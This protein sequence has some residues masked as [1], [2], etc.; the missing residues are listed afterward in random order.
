MRKLLIKLFKL[1]KFNIFSIFIAFSEDSICE[2]KIFCHTTDNSMAIVF[3]IPAM[4]FLGILVYWFAM[5]VR[6]ENWIYSDDQ[7]VEGQ[8]SARNGEN[9]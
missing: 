1:Y 7:N 9:L 5:F 4:F 3:I 2:L 8:H 6:S